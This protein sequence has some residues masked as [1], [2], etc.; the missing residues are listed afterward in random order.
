MDSYFVFKFL[1]Q[2]NY[3]PLE[4]NVLQFLMMVHI[5]MSSDDDNDNDA[6]EN[7]HDGV[8]TDFG[9]W[10]VWSVYDC[11]SARRQSL[12]MDCLVNDRARFT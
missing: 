5:M 4:V 10:E 12:K 6:I 11:I 3:V 7:N 2:H 1:Y 8:Q 9:G